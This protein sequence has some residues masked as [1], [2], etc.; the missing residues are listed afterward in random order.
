M[1]CAYRQADP[2]P[3]DEVRKIVAAGKRECSAFDTKGPRRVSRRRLSRRVDR[4]AV[5]RP[6]THWAGRSAR[7]DR[8]LGGAYVGRRTR[9]DGIS[10][11]YFSSPIKKPAANDGGS[12]SLI[13]KTTGT[14]S[15]RRSGEVSARR[16]ARTL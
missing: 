5:F 10:W 12:N 3:L 8:K 4:T 14:R 15:G 9:C 6:E 16:L 13:E 11:H 1:V 2:Y 7:A